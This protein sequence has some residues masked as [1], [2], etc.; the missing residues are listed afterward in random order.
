MKRLASVVAATT[1]TAIVF[2]NIDGGTKDVVDPAILVYITVIYTASVAAML[3]YT[4]QWS[5]IGAGLGA[6]MTGDALLYGRISRHI[7]VPFL[8]DPWVLDAIRAC[9]VVGATYIA[10]GL[11][12]WIRAQREADDDTAVIFREGVP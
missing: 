6:T 5:I 4:R 2:N 9:F 11:I 1:V 12:L 3:I 10:I 7:P 8:D